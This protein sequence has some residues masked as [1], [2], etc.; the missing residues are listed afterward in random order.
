MFFIHVSIVSY[1]PIITNNLLGNNKYST[2]RNRGY[3]AWEHF[4]GLIFW[5]IFEI[6]QAQ[7]LPVACSGLVCQ[8]RWGN[9]WK[10]ESQLWGCL[11]CPFSTSTPLGFSRSLDNVILPLFMNPD[12]G[13]VLGLVRATSSAHAEPRGSSSAFLF[14]A[15]FH[16][17]HP[18]LGCC[19]IPI[20]CNSSRGPAESQ[21]SA[22]GGAQSQPGCT[23]VQVCPRHGRQRQVETEKN[24]GVKR[25][26]K[27]EKLIFIWT[28]VHCPSFHTP[29]TKGCDFLVSDHGTD[30]RLANEWIT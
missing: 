2:C 25:E 1:F 20:D 4:P 17:H 5:L 27:R 6:P 11:I 23:W 26:E 15:S 24:N 12:G 19:S 21:C 3:E 18:Q 10:L 28:P 13:S 30:Q 29:L 8:V 7:G 9:E 22:Q 14:S 16:A